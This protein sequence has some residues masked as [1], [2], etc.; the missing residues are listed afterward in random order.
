MYIYLKTQYPSYFNRKF[1]KRSK[2]SAATQYFPKTITDT[3]N[4]VKYYDMENTEAKFEANF[5]PQDGVNTFVDLPNRNTDLN[6]NQFTY[7]EVY[8]SSNVFLSS[9]YVDDVKFIR[10]GIARVFLIRDVIDNYYDDIMTSTYFIERANLDTNNPLIMN[11]EGITLNQVKTSE[12]PLKLSECGW[13]VGYMARNRNADTTLSNEI[14]DSTLPIINYTNW[15]DV[16]FNSFIDYSSSNLKTAK[17]PFYNGAYITANFSSNSN[18]GLQAGR[19]CFPFW[20]GQ[21]ATAIYDDGVDQVQIN[22]FSKQPYKA[23]GSPKDAFD[24]KNILDSEYNNFITSISTTDY[25]RFKNLSANFDD[26][27]K[28]ELADNG[29]IGDD[30]LINNVLNSDGFIIHITSDNTF[31]RMTSEVGNT[32]KFARILYE[33]DNATFPDTYDQMDQN[34]ISEFALNISEFPFMKENA[35][36]ITNMEDLFQ[37]GY[38]Y[39]RVFINLDKVSIT[40]YST[41]VPKT[42]DLPHSYES[43]FDVFMIPYGDNI[44][45]K[46]NGS[47]YSVNKIAAI[48]CAS[49]LTVL[50]GAS[51][52]DVQLLPYAPIDLIDGM[53]TLAGLTSTF[54]DLISDENN[55]PIGFIYYPT[56]LSFRRTILLGDPIVNPTN[57]IEFKINNECDLYRL[58]SP[59][60]CGTFEFTATKNNGIEGFEINCTLKPQMPYIHINPIWGGLYGN[61]FNDARGLV[62][63]GDFSLSMASSA[64]ENYKLQNK[65]YQLAF[66]RQIDHMEVQ[67]KYQNIQSAIAA[68]TN[69]ISTGVIAG[70]AS[71]SP[72]AGVIAG[73]ASLAGGMADIKIQKKMQ[74]EEIGYTTDL[75]NYNLQ[76]IQA[77][78]YTLNKVSSFDIDSK[79]FPFLEYYTAT[80][81]E[82]QALRQHLEL[83]GMS[84]NRF[85]TLNLYIEDDYTYV[86]AKLIR[87][88]NVNIPNAIAN[89]IAFE[90]EKGVYI[91]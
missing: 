83:R 72:A 48:D 8:N 4:Q 59:N 25:N 36:T 77:I 33:T 62:C 76:N 22:T 81:E 63:S 42:S 43:P 55:N 65:N 89:Q 10:N 24:Y 9:W 19:Y 38:K 29:D 58:V 79:V 5:D 68:T 17:V 78:P 45:F 74:K 40:Q 46:Y 73:A 91:K 64:W 86:K 49:K 80:D 20:N 54:Y 12:T 53:P 39:K 16:P 7:C 6:W 56:E 37:L 18:T 34:I 67:Y 66:D 15:S 85:D 32:N 2:I 13:I 90:F 31:W 44:T 60:Y 1:T 28:A 69:A 30:S 70:A 71:G 82:K 14:P 35:G 21:E 88:S 26:I 61:D 3:T 41:N 87:L 11:S 51:I 52:Y 84:V 57:R 47:D 50:M 75:F 27:I 23:F